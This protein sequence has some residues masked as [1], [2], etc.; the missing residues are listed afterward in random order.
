VTATLRRLGAQA[1][2]PG[3]GWTY[4]ST[5]PGRNPHAI[6]AL[7]ATGP[8]SCRSDSLGGWNRHMRR[9]ANRSPLHR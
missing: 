3:A 5:L 6:I 1:F 4:Q 7:I 2:L 9:T 8:S